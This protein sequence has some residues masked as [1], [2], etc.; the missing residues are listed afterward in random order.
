LIGVELN[1]AVKPIIAACAERGLVL[2][3]AGDRILR[4][5]PPLIITEEQINKAMEILT[6]TCQE[7]QTDIIQSTT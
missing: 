6:A 3:S 7:Q 1:T 5:V 2:I 4:L